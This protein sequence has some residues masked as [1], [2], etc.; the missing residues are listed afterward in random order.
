VDTAQIIEIELDAA[1]ER[2]LKTP[3]LLEDWH[4]PTK[5]LPLMLMPVY[6]KLV[7]IA[8][9]RDGGTLRNEC[10]LI[11]QNWLDS[12]AKNRTEKFGIGKTAHIQ[13]HALPGI[14]SSEIIEGFRLK[15]PEKWKDKLKHLAKAANHYTKPFDDGLSALVQRGGPGK[16][17][18]TWNPAHFAVRLIEDEDNCTYSARRASIKNHWE[19]WLPEFDALMEDRGFSD[20]P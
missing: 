4:S 1:A 17:S 5:R 3:A 19:V 7:A 10:E 15:P 16:G 18:H 8:A 12:R 14:P 13:A 2:I 6:M 20:A 11:V 9:L